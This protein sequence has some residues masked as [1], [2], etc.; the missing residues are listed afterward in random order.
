MRELREREA[1]GE[2]QVQEQEAIIE[3]PPGQT[4]FAHGGEIPPVSHNT[5]FEP[6]RSAWAY[7]AG[8]QAPPKAPKPGSD[9]QP[10]Q[11]TFNTG[12]GVYTVSYELVKLDRTDKPGVKQDAMKLRIVF[13]PSNLVKSQNMG[14][15]QVARRSQN[16]GEKWST[17]EG[18]AMTGQRSKRTDEKSGFRL[19]RNKPM[20][21]PFA[22]TLGIDWW[23]MKYVCVKS[24]AHF[25]SGFERMAGSI[26][27]VEARA[28]LTHD[29]S[30]LKYKKGG[31][32]I[33]LEDLIP[34]TTYG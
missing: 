21:P 34:E 5:A 1:M 13:N 27:N 32:R 16:G 11:R 28:I 31:K 10:Q 26:Y 23:R 2:Q 24:A 9:R 25:R 4:Q 20:D 14:F 3:P 12:N 22:R 8:D 18:G 6:Q 33:R 15:V 17:E 19:D 29:W 30:T 7:D